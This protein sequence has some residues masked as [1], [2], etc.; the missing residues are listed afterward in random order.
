MTFT[1]DAIIFPGLL[2]LKDCL[3]SELASAGLDGQCQCVLL[4]GAGAQPALPSAGKGV[5]WVGLN[6]I[7]PSTTFPEPS[8]SASSCSA[9]LAASV[10]VG[11]IRCYQ[12]KTSG[13]SEEDMRTYMDLQM[14]DMAAMRRAILC[15]ADIEGVDVDLGT[16]SPIGPE[17]GIYGGMWSSVIGG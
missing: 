11:V 5:A 6:S 15:C 17:G 3:C 8:E 4:H 1:G 13:E 9:P 14:A 10:T 7:F 2:K 12:V 16:Y